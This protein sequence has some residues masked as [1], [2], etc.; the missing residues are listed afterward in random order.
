[1]QIYLVLNSLHLNIS[2]VLSTS[3]RMCTREFGLHKRA[4]LSVVRCSKDFTAF[5][6]GNG[7]GYFSSR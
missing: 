4:V 2:I 5:F 3:V 7:T 6:V 1:M